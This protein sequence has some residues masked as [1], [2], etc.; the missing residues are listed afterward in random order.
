MEVCGLIYVVCRKLREQA[1]PNLGEIWRW[2]RKEF[3]KHRN[4][5]HFFCS[6][7][8]QKHCERCGTQ[9]KRAGGTESKRYGK[10]EVPY[11]LFMKTRLS[12]GWSLQK[13]GYPGILVSEMPRY[14]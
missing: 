2:K 9:E 6:G 10:R 8:Q 3:E 1:R 14:C 4:I 13:K 12:V 11:P 5:E 7:K